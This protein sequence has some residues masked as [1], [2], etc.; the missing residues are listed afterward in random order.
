MI[1]N[2]KFF[3]SYTLK[4]HNNQQLI[5]TFNIIKYPLIIQLIT[6]LYQK[7]NNL[8]FF[9]NYTLKQSKKNT[10]YNFINIKQHYIYIYIQPSQ[11]IIFY[12]QNYNIK[13]FTFSSLKNI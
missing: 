11:Q 2:N 7:F 10:L 3:L 13:L 9:Y 8:T 5:P 4:T 6:L 1:T 12:H